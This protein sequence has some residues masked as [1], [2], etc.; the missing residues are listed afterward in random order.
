MNSQL[1]DDEYIEYE[2]LPLMRLIL[3]WCIVIGSF[4]FFSFIT[5]VLFYFW[6]VTGHLGMVHA[7]IPLILVFVIIL[8][9]L[10]V[11]LTL[12]ILTTSMFGLLFIEFLL[13][14]GKFNKSTSVSSINWIFILIPLIIVE[15]FWLFHLIYISIHFYYRK[16]LLDKSQQVA[17][18]SY[19]I[20]IILM[21]IADIIKINLDRFN[22]IKSVIPEILW[23]FSGVLF[24]FSVLVI[25]NNELE[26]IAISKNYS[27][28]LDIIKTR[29][30]HWQIREDGIP[31]QSVLLGM[32]IR[33][34]NRNEN[35]QPNSYF[36]YNSKEIK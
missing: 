6:L 33:N 17:L 14:I 19:S 10:Y 28:P 20:S 11:T 26:K 35:I 31:F 25:I 4:L 21:I 5:Q 18:I 32:I 12:S 15:C 16:F 8:A 9:Y 22:N 3:F 30:G 27:E 24:S 7:C 34:K 2:S 36:Q 1:Q 23:M 13:F 29:G